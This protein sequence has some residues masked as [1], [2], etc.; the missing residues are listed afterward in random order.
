MA[1]IA[2]QTLGFYRDNSM[3]TR[4][5]VADLISDV[6]TIYERK[7]AYKDLQLGLEVDPDL[8]ITAMGGELKQILSNLLSNAIDASSNGG[9]ILLRARPFRDLRSGSSGVRITI[10]DNGV[11][12]AKHHKPQLFAPFFTTKKDVGTGLGLWITKDLVQKKG[13]T[14]HLRSSDK[15]RL[16]RLIYFPARAEAANTRQERAAENVA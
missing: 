11:G 12:I 5:V 13:G 7:L 16:V 3:P 6:L 4:L 14:I 2:Q 8:T 1:H 15:S 10:A 9:K